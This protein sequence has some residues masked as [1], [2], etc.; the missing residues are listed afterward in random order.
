MKENL[1]GLDEVNKDVKHRISSDVLFLGV[2]G[3]TK[4]FTFA[5]KFFKLIKSCI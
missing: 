5:S 1:G 3:G 4:Q 2:G